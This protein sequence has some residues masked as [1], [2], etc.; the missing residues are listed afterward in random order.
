[1]MEMPEITGPMAA[2]MAGLVTSL[3]C[4][5]MCGPLACAACAVYGTWSI[6]PR[7]IIPRRHVAWRARTWRRHAA[8]RPECLSQDCERGTGF[9]KHGTDIPVCRPV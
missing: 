6:P 7:S 9:R 2:L 5:G 4:A 3:H 8:R 1:M